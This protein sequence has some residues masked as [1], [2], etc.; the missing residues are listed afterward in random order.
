MLAEL[1]GSSP[2]AASV[3]TTSSIVV[4]EN[5]NRKKLVLCNDG[6]DVIYLCRGQSVAVNTGIRLPSG[7]VLVDEPDVFGKMYLGPWA[8][9]VGTTTSILT[10]SE[11]GG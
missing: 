5:V 4:R 3:T 11:D 9:I 7:A 10:I 2:R 8:G 6:S 1:P